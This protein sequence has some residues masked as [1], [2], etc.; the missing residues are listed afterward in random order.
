MLKILT[1]SANM[2]V[3]VLIGAFAVAYIG[4]YFPD[5]LAVLFDWGD[6]IAKGIYKLNVIS[7]QAMNVVRFLINGQ[8][9][10]FLTLV[11]LA[12]VLLA[13]GGMLISSARR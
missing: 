2:F 1:T 3:S 7:T 12:R 13:F 5:A 6:S 10:V 11:I 9:L 4:I 8:Q